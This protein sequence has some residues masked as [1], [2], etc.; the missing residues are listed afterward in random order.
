MQRA[1]SVEE[2]QSLVEL[3][4]AQLHHEVLKN[5]IAKREIEHL[6]Q[7][8]AEIIFRELDHDN[9]GFILVEHL[10]RNGDGKIMHEDLVDL[11]ARS[12]HVIGMHH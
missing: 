9:K 3:L 4:R 12:P 2:L 7:T 6:K 11:H 5:N 10:D 8:T 1:T